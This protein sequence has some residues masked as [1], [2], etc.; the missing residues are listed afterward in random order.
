VTGSD[1]IPCQPC[2]K[3]HNAFV[4]I[5]RKCLNSARFVCSATE[6]HAR[7]Y[8]ELSVLFCSQLSSGD[9]WTIKPVKQK[10][11]VGAF[12]RNTSRDVLSALIFHWACGNR[13]PI[14]ATSV[15]RRNFCLFFVSSV[16]NLNCGAT[17]AVA[18][19][20]LLGLYCVDFHLLNSVFQFTYCRC[21]RDAARLTPKTSQRET[22]VL[23]L[24]FKHRHFFLRFKISRISSLFSEK[25]TC[26][27]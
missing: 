24:R 3:F 5:L 20:P 7:K 6:L 25:S 2:V 9:S 21:N 10:Q 14:N 22:A 23:G 8:N 11:M 26:L 15:W 16:A 18:Y 1:G 4:D 12:T 17:V 27:E 19:T 13:S